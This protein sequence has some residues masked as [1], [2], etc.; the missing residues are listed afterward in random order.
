VRRTFPLIAAIVVIGAV[1]GLAGVATAHVEVQP[2][3]APEGQPATFSFRM[4]NED[5]KADTISLQVRFPAGP[6]VTG[7]AAP[8]M[9]GWTI[10]VTN[11][12]LPAPVTVGA[13]TVTE[14]VDTI[15][16]TGA[17]PPGRAD[18]FNVTTGPLPSDA[19]EIVFSATQ[20]YSDGQVVVWDQ[21]E[22]AGGPE[23]AHPAPV[24]AITGATAA[25]ATTTPA[26]TTVTTA[27][28]A[29]TEGG[30]G[31]SNV[32]TVMFVAVIAVIVAGGVL[33]YRSVTRRQAKPEPGPK[34]PGAARR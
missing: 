8:P 30:G 18:Y 34:G 24:L 5:P 15:T 3:Q 14:V 23:P 2:A 4:P 25:V 33:L 11:R 20:T 7:V 6:V 32:G 28:A 26:L 27:A 31:S 21:P 16:W 22:V 13:T 19:A 12:T 17:L 29:Q 1:V 10:A 9:D